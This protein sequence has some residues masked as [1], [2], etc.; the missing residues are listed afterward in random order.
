MRPFIS[1]ALIL[2]TTTAEA[3]DFW[4]T[5]DRFIVRP[6]EP[7]SISFI[8]G[9]AGDA[10]PWNLR[11]ERVVEL[12]ICKAGSCTPV[13]DIAP[14]TPEG[15]G[16]ARVSVNEA[17]TAIIAF[18][19]RHSFSELDGDRFNEYAEKEGLRAIL[20]DRAERFSES[21]PGREL[22]SRR[23]KT[24]IRVEG[25]GS[26]DAIRAVGHTLEIVP[27]EDLSRI[28]PGDKFSVRV[29]FNGAPLEG[30]TIDLDNLG[31]QLG[32]VQSAVTNADGDA[33]F[34]AGEP[35]PWK[36]MSVWGVPLKDRSRADYETFFASLTFSY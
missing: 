27:L 24:L 26:D 29:L 15:P 10:E 18:E 25:G 14:N 31:D 36:L 35:G 34:A 5:P 7:V 4:L 3:H 23:A 9:H 20:A 12:K 11:Q 21:D 30:A 32:P 17:G 6:G 1:A 16:R 13:S 2:G 28:D 22:Y 19:S 33:A 8:V